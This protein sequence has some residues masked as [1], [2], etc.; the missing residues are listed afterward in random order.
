MTYERYD[1]A[2][3]VKPDGTFTVRETQ[4][5]RFDGEFS[6]AFA[7]IPLAYTTRID[8][9]T[10]YEGDTPYTVGGDGPGTYTTEYGDD[11]LAVDWTFEQHGL[12]TCARL[13]WRIPSSAGLDLSRRRPL[14]W[15]A[16]PA[17]RSGVPVEA[18]RV[19]VALPPDPA[20]GRPVPADDLRATPLANRQALKPRRAGCLR[21]ERS[22]PRWH[23][24]PG[25]GRLSA[26]PGRGEPQAWQIAEDTADLAYRYKSLDTD[27]TINADGSVTWWSG[28]TSPSRPAR[29]ARASTISSTRHGRRGRRG[30]VGR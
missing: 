28:T 21:S 27:F 9:V 14:E 29:C 16:V 13:R 8:D 26:R 25:A 6:Q 11:K 7:E 17:D 3:D 1:V 10:I 15:R 12:A 22:H 18:S 2:I 23:A 24:A 30:R 5:I 19:T 20:T 4:Q